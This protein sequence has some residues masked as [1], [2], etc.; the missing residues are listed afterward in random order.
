[1]KENLEW[2]SYKAWKLRI[3][4]S[5]ILTFSQSSNLIFFQSCTLSILNSFQSYLHSSNLTLFLS[6][7]LPI[8]LSSNFALFQSLHLQILHSSNFTLFQF[9]ILPILHSYILPTIHSSN[10]TLPLQSYTLPV[11]GA[12]S[13]IDRIGVDGG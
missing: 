8:L 4:H 12:F 11:V 3:T 6:Y 10:L 7:T 5:H 1:M 9:Y 2:L 13:V